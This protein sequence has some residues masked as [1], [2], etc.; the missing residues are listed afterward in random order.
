MHQLPKAAHSPELAMEAAR[1]TNPPALV[2]KRDELTSTS[3]APN[4]ASAQ[5]R[6]HSRVRMGNV[7]NRHRIIS[8]FGALGPHGTAT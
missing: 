1:P 2:E 4:P 8:G 7:A 5:V 3:E 6:R